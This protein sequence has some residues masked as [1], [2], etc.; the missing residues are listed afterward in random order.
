MGLPAPSDDIAVLT[1]A[2]M[3][4]LRSVFSPGYRYV[5]SGVM[6]MDLRNKGVQQGDLFGA[7]AV[8]YDD[9]REALLSTLDHVNG[10]WGRGTIGIGSAG[11]QEKRPWAMQRG[12]MSASFTT[13]WSD[14]ACAKA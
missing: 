13:K 10:R 3:V 12:N 1:Q 5:K 4:V 8:A 14:L 6:L 11:L 9:R 2:A 7:S